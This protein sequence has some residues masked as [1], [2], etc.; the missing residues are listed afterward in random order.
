MKS[1][2][3]RLRQ[4]RWQH[5]LLHFKQH[6]LV[7]TRPHP[8]FAT[9]QSNQEPGVQPRHLLYTEMLKENDDGIRFYTGL[10]SWTVFQHPVS[11]L[12]VCC[13]NLRT[14]KLSPSDSILLTLMRLRLNLRLEDLSYRRFGTSI[15][16]I[17][18]DFHRWIDIYLRLYILVH[19]A[20]STVLRSLLSGHVRTRHEHRFT[21]T[22]R[23]TTWYC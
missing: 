12:S 16:T 23:N 20:L 19:D 3:A 4:R 7:P 2:L 6:L 18:Y 21:P 15:L 17:N 10:S 9:F 11:F 8:S 22:T 1:G 13:P 14:L 5:R